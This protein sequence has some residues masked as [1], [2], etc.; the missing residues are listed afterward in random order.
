MTSRSS[1]PTQGSL[2]T[3]Q[4]GSHRS[5]SRNPPSF[6]FLSRQSKSAGSNFLVTP[7]YIQSAHK[8]MQTPSQKYCLS[9]SQT[10]IL[11]CFYLYRDN[12]MRYLQRKTFSPVIW[13]LLLLL[14]LGWIFFFIF[15]YNRVY[16]IVL[17]LSLLPSVSSLSLCLCLSLWFFFASFSLLVSGSRPPLNCCKTQEVWSVRRVWVVPSNLPA[18]PS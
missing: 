8:N 7:C 18:R 14:L 16:P 10:F 11:V 1:L 17:H 6:P 4:M 5:S 12:I 2:P 3:T 9:P 13:V 15:F